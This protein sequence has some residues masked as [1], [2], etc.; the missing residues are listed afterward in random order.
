MIEDI[1][2]RNLKIGSL[3]LDGAATGDILSFTND[4]ANFINVGS[5]GNVLTSAGPGLPPVFTPPGALIVPDPLTL[6]RV[7]LNILGSNASPSISVLA[8]LILNSTNTNTIFGYQ[9]STSGLKNSIFGNNALVSSTSDSNS[10][11]GYRA[12]NA[13]NS[14]EST[15][16]GCEALDT[17]TSQR[18]TSMGFQAGSSTNY[19]DFCSFGYRAGANSVSGTFFGSQSGEN[20][21]GNDVVGFGRLAALDNT[22]SNNI[23]IGENSFGGTDDNN[24]LIGNN[25]IISNIRNSVVIRHDY[26]NSNTDAIIIG[27]FAAENTSQNVVA[28]GVSSGQ[29][30][31]QDGT[32]LGNRANSTGTGSGNTSVG[33]ESFYLGNLS[34]DCVSVGKQ[35]NYTGNNTGTVAIGAYSSNAAEGLG[36]TAIGYYS[37]N[38][39]TGS[40]N[41]AVGYESGRSFVSRD[42]VSVFGYRAGNNCG[43]RSS[44]FGVQALENAPF[45][46]STAFGYRAGQ[47]NS[48]TSSILVGVNCG[49]NNNSSGLIA[50]GDDAI[51][52]GT[53]GVSNIVI[54]HSAVNI[55]NPL[56]SSVVLGH[57]ALNN[58]VDCQNSVFVGERSG[59]GC[60]S[61]DSVAIGYESGHYAGSFDIAVG[62]YAQKFQ[63]GTTSGNNIF[64]GTNSGLNGSGNVVNMIALGNNTFLNPNNTSFDIAIGHEALKNINAGVS[65]IGIGNSALLNGGNN[66]IGIGSF[67]LFKGSNFGCVAVGHNTL[68]GNTNVESVAVGVSA[69]ADSNSTN[70]VYIGRSAGSGTNTHIDCVFIGHNAQLTNSTTESIIIGKSANVS[71]NRSIAIGKDAKGG[72]NSIAIGYNSLSVGSTSN[73]GIG[74]NTIPGLAGTLNVAIG[75]RALDAYGS[76]V[77]DNRSTA[78][79]HQAGAGIFNQSDLT[80]FGFQANSSGSFS[81][82]IGSSAMVS[83]TESIAIGYNSLCSTNFSVQLGNSLIGGNGELKFRSQLVSSETWIGGGLTTASIDNSGNIIRTPSDEKLKTNI[84]KIKVNLDDFMKLKPVEYNIKK[85]SNDLEYGFLAQEVEKIFPFFVSSGEY[86]SLKYLQFIPLIVKVLQKIITKLNL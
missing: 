6:N 70:N 2:I 67:S 33:F 44:G 51:I 8:D 30:T 79:G 69:G 15:A 40:R 34:N 57:A 65:R 76:F 3:K 75:F 23:F 53:T 63:P 29:S 80:F 86:K 77:N 60:N 74:E 78:V 14:G 59:R 24:I 28:I 7:N 71:G 54:G 84:K 27:R 13:N 64:I 41:T 81:T 66:S 56:F 72:S 62:K 4:E 20:N 35:A 73:I 17:S 68:S 45:G 18:G 83:A 42:D 38:S 36:T 37:L 58:Y 61:I 11:F 49:R 22:G 16:F 85:F 5:A 26:Q 21:G 19:D 10:A 46:E 48:G 39:S 25:K 12:L 50:I 9:S 31:G 55:L 47:N 43:I 1:F 32:A 52:N 82:A